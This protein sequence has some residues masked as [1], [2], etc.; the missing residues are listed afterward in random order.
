[1]IILLQVLFI[2]RLSVRNRGP[3]LP[4]RKNDPLLEKDKGLILRNLYRIIHAKLCS[5]AVDLHPVLSDESNRDFFFFHDDHLLL[6]SG[7]SSLLCYY[8]GHGKKLP[9]KHMET[10]RY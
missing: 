8:P 5:L 4:S 6:E 2:D 7:P 1:M 10:A 3:E 9:E